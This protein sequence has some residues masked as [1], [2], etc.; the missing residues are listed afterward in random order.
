MAQ[1][2][3][4]IAISVGADIG[5]LVRELGKASGAVSK[6]GKDAQASGGGM[7]LATK[8]GAALG[9]SVIAAGA[10][11]VVFTRAAMNNIDAL[12]KQARVAGVAVSTFQA[13]SLVAEEAGVS[14]EQ[15]SK[16]LVK[17][18]DNITQLGRGGAA[19]I[20]TFDQLGISFSQ[21]GTLAADAQF[22]LIAERISAISD[23]TLRTSAALDV[24]GKS[25]ADALNMMTGYGAAIANATAFQEEFGLAVSDLDAANI[26]AANDAIGRS[27]IA[28]QS[29]GT[30][31]AVTFAP[32]IQ[33]VAI[34]LQMLVHDVFAAETALERIFGSGEIARAIL[35]EDIYNQ[36]NRDAQ[37][38]ENVAREVGELSGVL[39][40]TSNFADQ[41]ATGFSFMAT[42]LEALGNN[43]IADKFQDL[44]ENIQKANADFAAGISNIDEYKAALEAARVR[45]A[46]LMVEASKIDGV[47][48]SNVRGQVAGLGFLLERVAIKAM[49]LRMALSSIGGATAGAGASGSGTIDL[50]SRMAPRTSPRPE[51]PPM[52]FGF[53][54]GS[55]GGSGGS[56]GGSGG[57]GGGNS[58]ADALARLQ[59]QFATESEVMQAQYDER[60]LQ[61]E[62]FRDQKILSEQA[63]NELEAK[64]KEDHEGK[65]SSIESKERSAR[66]SELA[67]VFGD[68]ATLT[69]SGNEKL[70]KIGQAAKV[71]EAVVTGYKAAIEAW[72]KGMTR[73]GPGMAS[74]YAAA[75][76][77]KTGA[78]IASMKSQ[79][80]SGGGSTTG[81]GAGGGKVTGGTT[82][83]RTANINFYGGFQPTQETIGMIASGLNDWLGD[84]GRLNMRGA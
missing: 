38:F 56:G 61:L 54:V 29:L 60:I 26:E 64:I 15:L 37:A 35:G 51:Q 57:S 46:E 83:T 13:M 23:P 47:N 8:A 41:A 81:G 11:M 14:S 2:I 73:G 70:F 10:A 1:I 80:S 24:F 74:A 45:A 62:T 76:L 52:D 71:A 25:G 82:E 31:L 9:A 69:R 59:E 42:S 27:G 48:L 7:A 55:G 22:E 12:S 40:A 18:Q 78:L 53:D 3:G 58:G 6:F 68:L 36:L 43:D 77:A 63:Y 34:G 67:G 28:I 66:L 19:Q 79:S 17:M 75:S 72:D 32:G 44:A 39:E 84:G 5:P 21:I 16:S 20:A 50:Q 65:L 33:K 49:Q 4:D 30:Q